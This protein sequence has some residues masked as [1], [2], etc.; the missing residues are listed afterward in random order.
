MS[1][2]PGPDR[3]ELQLAALHAALV[4]GRLPGA[5]GD[6]GRAVIYAYVM[7]HRRRGALAPLALR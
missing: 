4:E 1:E 7:W 2:R 5:N 3:D 6:L